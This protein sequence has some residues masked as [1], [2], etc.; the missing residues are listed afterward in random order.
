[1]LSPDW[2][3]WRGKD[4]SAASHLTSHWCRLHRERRKIISPSVSAL[5]EGKPEILRQNESFSFLNS[6]PNRGRQI[7]GLM[8][9]RLGLSWAAVFMTRVTL[10]SAMQQITRSQGRLGL[11]ISDTKPEN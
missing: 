5:V 10:A 8:F 4:S 6:F 11:Q 9:E 7:S 2:S 3:R 1:M